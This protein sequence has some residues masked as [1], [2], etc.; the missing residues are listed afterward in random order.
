MRLDR[1][2]RVLAL[3][4]LALLPAQLPAYN[5]SGQRWTGTTVV[6]QL[7]LGPSSGALLDGS[8]SWGAAA[9][10]ALAQWNASLT[11]VHFTVVRDSTAP[12]ASG[13]GFNN[14]FW[15]PTV[16]G[17]AWGSRTLAITLSNYNTSTHAYTEADVL[18]NNTLNWNS[19]RG[20]LRT[21]AGGGT[22]YDFHRVALHEFGHA[23]GLNHPDDIGQ[24]VS[25]V[26]NSA[27]SNVDSLT[28]DDIA[29]AQAI[30]DGAGAVV[31]SLLGFQG[32]VGYSSSGTGLNL[33]VGS[34]GNTGNAT[35]G[36][37]RLELWAMP[38]HFANGLPTGSINLGIYAFPTVLAAGAS[39]AGVNVNTR[40]AVPPDGT[41]FV[42]LLLTE[43]TGGSGSGYTIRDSIEFSSQLTAAGGTAPVI[44]KQPASFTVS[45]GAPVTLSVTASPGSFYQWQFNGSNLAGATSPSLSVGNVQPANAGLYVADVLNSVSTATASDAAVVGVTTTNKVIGAGAEIGSNITAPNKNIYDQ[46][47][48]SGAAATITAD[49]GQIMR[50]S[51]IDANDDSV[52][53]EFGGAGALTMVLDTSSG[54]AAPLNYNQPAVAYMKGHVGIVIT[55]A[56]ETTNVS[57]FSVGRFT[58]FDPTGKFDSTQPIDANANNPA[59]NGSSLF[60]GHDATVY[61]GVADLAFIA[62]LSTDGQFGGVRTAN[63]RYSAA[64]G[65]TGIYAPGVTFT[66]PVYVGD[67]SASAQ[68]TPVLVLGGATNNTWVTGG[69]LLQTNGQPVR[70]S[71]ITQL[72]FMAGSDSGGNLTAA[73]TNRAV[74]LQGGTDVTA[75]LVV[76]PGP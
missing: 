39:F 25:A 51:F 1:G 73:K 20:A 54:P 69:A 6:M 21:A 23:L 18:F 50:T 40:Y 2:A 71:G 64:K 9:E 15:S 5:L 76:N 56:D 53:V 8:A 42:V 28:A 66:G 37:V 7:Q 4:V 11:N 62:I 38:Q 68:A 75:Q 10:D 61:D 46:V 31:A 47:L 34:V 58:A 27:T 22:L 55:G 43:F 67:I 74:L 33:R 30:Y 12:M 3:G 14:V 24:S 52:Q 36:T 60:V 16:Y 59:N 70:V 65:L 35:S 26:M 32:S 72:K 44:T 63:A 48:L 45:A 13:N 17:G 29:G 49:S 57:V 19:Y 41:Y